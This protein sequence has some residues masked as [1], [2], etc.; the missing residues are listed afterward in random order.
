M[1]KKKFLKAYGLT[2]KKK[3]LFCGAPGCG[4]TVCA[5]AVANILDLPILYTC[6]DGLISSYL[7]ETSSNI[8]KV[9]LTLLVKII[10]FFFSINLM[11]LVK[12]ERY[13]RRT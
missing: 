5:E 10:G 11:Q 4:K 13:C 1:R 6:F 9:F 3:L 8:R 12:V 7:G 2:P